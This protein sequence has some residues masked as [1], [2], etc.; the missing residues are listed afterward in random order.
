VTEAEIKAEYDRLFANRPPELEFN[1]QHILVGT[2]DEAKQVI[3][4]LGGGEE[5]AALAKELTQDPSG[6]ESGGDLGW[7]QGREM[8][9]EFAGAVAAMKAGETSS[10]PVQTQF[11]WHVIKLNETRE[12]PKPPLDALAPQIRAQLGSR[13][14]D[15][16]IQ[17]LR[18]DAKIERGATSTPAATSQAP[19]SGH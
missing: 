8:V 3:A 18:Q 15:E 2:E 1:A 12:A 17:K 9:P 13:K 4:R 10:A 16:M 14:L 6:K 11:G 7:F 19:A 5:F